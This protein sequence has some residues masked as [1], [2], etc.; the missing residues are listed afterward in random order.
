MW[1]EPPAS[2]KLA[3]NAHPL[4]N[5]GRQT[6]NEI[7]QTLQYAP[8]HLEELAALNLIQIFYYNYFRNHFSSALSPV[9]TRLCN[10][11]HGAFHAYDNIT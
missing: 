1:L 10:T 2:G 5:I 9:F 7:Q 6:S 11:Q 4:A 3:W 8:S